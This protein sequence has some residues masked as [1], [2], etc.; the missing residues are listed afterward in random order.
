[1]RGPTSSAEKKPSRLG[2]IHRRAVGGVFR[3]PRHLGDVEPK[4]SFCE[5]KKTDDWLPLA[6]IVP[7]DKALFNY[8]LDQ[9]ILNHQAVP[10]LKLLT[11]HVQA[12]SFAYCQTT[13]SFCCWHRDFSTF[14]FSQTLQDK[15]PKGVANFRIYCFVSA[16]CAGIVALQFL[17]NTAVFWDLPQKN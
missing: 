1:M 4:W 8:E 16:I 15:L 5:G 11:N 6:T 14:S 7:S 13:V 10:K 9:V 2:P 3:P 12:I 17:A